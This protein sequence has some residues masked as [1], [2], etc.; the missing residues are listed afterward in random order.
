MLKIFIALI[1]I[2][3]ME[4]CAECE[5]KKSGKEIAPVENAGFEIAM[6]ILFGAW[7]ISGGNLLW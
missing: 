5:R 6:A 4:Y 2:G 3:F 1:A 7:I